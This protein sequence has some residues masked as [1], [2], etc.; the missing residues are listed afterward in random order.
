MPTVITNV[1]K[2]YKNPAPLSNKK[3][4]TLVLLACLR[5]TTNDLGAQ[6]KTLIDYFNYT[7]QRAGFI[8]S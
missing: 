1:A 2:P 4:A 8:K 7:I 5:V 3:A 6:I